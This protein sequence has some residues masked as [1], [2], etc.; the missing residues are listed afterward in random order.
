[1]PRQ[2][3]Q[4]DGI[5]S[6]KNVK[7]FLKKSKKGSKMTKRHPSGWNTFQKS[8]VIINVQKIHS[9]LRKLVQTTQAYPYCESGCPHKYHWIFREGV[10]KQ[11]TLKPGYLK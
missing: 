6:A 11:K 10:K 7:R 1:M 8:Y 4:S 3:I 9:I 2:I 5:F